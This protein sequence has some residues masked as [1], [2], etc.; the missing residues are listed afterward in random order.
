MVQS[1]EEKHDRSSFKSLLRLL[2]FCFKVAPKEM[3]LVMIVPSM[4]GLTTLMTLWSLQKLIDVANVTISTE[5]A[6][7]T[8][9]IMWLSILIFSI[10][11]ARILDIS[12]STIT[13]H[14]Q[15]T[16]KEK[17]KS[18]IIEKA[19][20]LS[21]ADFD[22]P[23]FYDRLQRV[24]QGVDQRF[25]STMTFIV[26]SMI[27]ITSILSIIIYLL[28]IHWLIPLV[29]LT[30]SLIFTL[31]QVKVF[32]EKYLLFRKQT[33][34][35]RKLQYIGNLM[36]SREA[37]S[38]I[39]LYGLKDYFLHS[40]NRINNE[41]INERMKL[42]RRSY[43]LEMAGSSGHTFTFAL[44]LFGILLISA[45]STLSTGQYAAFIRAAVTFQQDLIDLMFNIAIINDDLRYI[46]DFFIYMDLPEEKR[47]GISLETENVL[48]QGIRINNVDFSYPGTNVQVLKDLNLD[49]QPGEKIALI[50]DNGSG[51]STLIKLLLGLY[52]PKK[53]EIL[54]NGMDLRQIDL[55]EW[56]TQTTAIFQDFQKF[57]LLNV[58]ENIAVGQIENI[59][60]K[61]KVQQAAF[62]AGADEMIQALPKGYETLLG[63]E[64]GGAELSQGQWQKVAIARAYIRNAKLL[65]LDEPT[66]SLDPKA[67]VEIYRQFE[68]VAKD[69]TAVFI[70]H[71]LGVA[72]LA[73]RIIVLKDGR[74]EEQGTHSELIEKNGAYAKMYQLQA[75]WYQ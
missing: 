42:A 55:N 51:K 72:K 22:Q 44:S 16:I 9:V 58:H 40:W 6:S 48:E 38:E 41:L 21:L 46:N 47:E 5:G 36:T 2:K 18:E 53:G 10:L 50:G 60:E 45:R 66:A 71:R 7:Y 70:S 32:K 68:Q 31:I 29:L 49:I 13:G 61:D 54:I 65:I 56:R 67:E 34:P 62:L 39:R 35:A 69:K 19:Y 59:N 25:L 33:T 30:G 52:L 3:I 74:V 57:Q 73:D 23:S 17:W 26:Q 1:Q 63:K 12:G 20:R 75:Q 28:F 24:N 8:P 11:L 4:I 27:K 14:L 37:A 43:R 64:F 15:G